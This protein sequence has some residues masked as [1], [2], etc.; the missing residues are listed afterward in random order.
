MVIDRGRGELGMTNGVD[1]KIGKRPVGEVNGSRNRV[2]LVGHG[3][4][5]MSNQEGMSGNLCTTRSLPLKNQAQRG[6]DR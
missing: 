4:F 1:G 3:S 5:V 2:V 6:Q